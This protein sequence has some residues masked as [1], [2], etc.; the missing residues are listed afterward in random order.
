M[1]TFATLRALHTC[2]GS[3]LSDLERLYKERSPSPSSPL[4][5]PSLDVPHYPNSAISPTDE[6]A[7]K[8]VNDRSAVVAIGYIVAACGQMSAIV[9]RPGV[10]VR[11]VAVSVRRFFSPGHAFIV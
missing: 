4:D 3:A 10:C 9:K 2:I 1:T 11:D 5:Y 7:E 6:L 8:L